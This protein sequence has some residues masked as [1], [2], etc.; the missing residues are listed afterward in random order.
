MPSAGTVCRFAWPVE[1]T[2]LTRGLR[3]T[4][5]GAIATVNLTA[6][7]YWW[8]GDGTANDLCAALDT[9]LQ[10]HPQ[11]PAITIY[12]LTTGEIRIVSNKTLTIHWADALTTADEVV[13]GCTAADLTAVGGP[14]WYSVTTPNQ[15]GHIWNPERIY[16]DDT[17]L[18]PQNT[19]S[20]SVDLSGAPTAYRWSSVQI[21]DITIDLIPFEKLLTADSPVSEAFDIF[22]AYISQGQK[23][24]WTPDVSTPGTYTTYYL[25]D[26]SQ[27]ETWPWER[28]AEVTRYHRVT[29]RM[30]LTTWG[31]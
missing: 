1:V 22:Y 25:R 17:G 29:L 10:S 7:T 3:V 6:G 12:L 5:N 27:M 2:S 4:C 28:I 14:P 20:R 24:V 23:F 30:Q 19:V 15:V 31:A 16:C 9:A 26:V 8:L 11:A 13:F 18:V 21:R